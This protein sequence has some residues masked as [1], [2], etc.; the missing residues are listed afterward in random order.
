M[1]RAA[2]TVVRLLVRALFRVRILGLQHYHAAGDRV[3]I[4]A[5]HVS[6]LDGALL[7]LFLP[8]PPLFA[9]DTR[10]AAHPLFR[11]LLACAQTVRLDPT[12]AMSTKALVKFLRQDRRAAIFPEGRITVT[13]ALM[14][15][16]EGAAMVAERAQA[17]ILP[18]GIEGAQYSPFSYLRGQVRIRWFPRI[19]LRVHPPVRL[20]LDGT[21]SGRARRA[22]AARAL[23]AIMHSVAFDNAFGRGTVF[24]ALIDALRRH[25]AGRIAAEDMER[26]PATLRSIVLRAFA[27]GGVLGR[28]TR[29]GE[30]VGLLLPNLVVTIVAFFAL[31]TR[32]RI[33]AMLNFASGPK[34]LA[35][36]CETAGIRTVYTSRRFVQAAR[37]EGAVEAIGASAQVVFLE[38]LRTS[39]RWVDR[40]AGVA[41]AIAPRTMYR[42]LASGADP[43]A[44]AV[45]LF[46]SGSEGVPKGVALSHANLL[47]NR[48]QIRV[49]VDLS[50][51]DVVFN[52]MP[53]FHSFGLTGG[54]LL[55]LLDGA[56]VFLYPTPLHY[57]LIPELCYELNATVLFGSNTFLAGYA[58]TANPYDF[59]AMRYVVAGAEKLQDDTRRAWYEKFG[60]RVLEGYGATEASPVIAVNTP[61]A[62]RSGSVGRLLTG[63]EHYL[64]P[65]EGIEDA[66]RL[67][68]RGPNVMRG[69]LFHG[70]DGIVP[71]ATDRGPGWY[72]TGDVVRIDAEG[73]I[74]IV[75]RGKRFAKVGGEM[76]S[77]TAVE[78]LA[79]TVWQGRPHAAVS[80]QDSRR[81]E[82]IVLVTAQPGATRRALADA[83]RAHGDNELLVPRHVIVVPQ[84]PVLGTGKFDYRAVA[85]LAART[86]ASGTRP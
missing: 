13:G 29:P 16:Y 8:E 42:L 46:T 40:L 4:V 33:P 59:R 35:I 58:R 10:I 28:A 39:A 50:A 79:A 38:D 23:A 25:G 43:D 9:V 69:Y 22:A 32:G 82:Q 20:A 44:T 6:L 18:V 47:A 7:W 36:A 75:G 56:R 68:I 72:D 77:L 53:V 51:R 66:G 60:I 80:F 37:L 54:T 81:G 30:H 24:A 15:I 19:T 84:V 52:C 76:I 70:N 65:V 73:F 5:N 27:L 78:E 57:R 49:H 63:I 3:L 67:V 61:M 86:L 1:L 34:A 41:G 17:A 62:A 31:H 14:K 26:R 64:A 45:V 11:P 71:P 21:L 12:N 48:A 2:R 83:A 55:P 85:D 74:T